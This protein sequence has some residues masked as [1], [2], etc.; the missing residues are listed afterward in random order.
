MKLLTNGSISF[1]KKMLRWR[2]CSLYYAVLPKCVEEEG[3]D[4]D[5]LT[6]L[7]VSKTTSF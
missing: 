3:E 1:I 5:L 4:D 2:F 6:E 7:L